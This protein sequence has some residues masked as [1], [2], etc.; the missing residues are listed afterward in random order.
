MIADT[1][2]DY[3]KFVTSAPGSAVESSVAYLASMYFK[4]SRFVLSFRFPRNWRFP[5]RTLRIL[6]LLWRSSLL[7]NGT[8]TWPLLHGSHLGHFPFKTFIRTMEPILERTD[9]TQP[10]S[11]VHAYV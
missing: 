2:W 1:C 4:T 11:C 6:E 3:L 9:L 7:N 5:R 8:A 10:T